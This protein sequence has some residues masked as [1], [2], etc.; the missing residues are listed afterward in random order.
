MTGYTPDEKLRLQQLRELRR[1]WLKDQELSP[2]EPVLPAQRMW[3]ME[4][5]WNKFLQDRAPWKNVIYKVYRTSIF[6][7]TCVLIPTWIV[8]YYVKYHVSKKPY[9][10]VERKPRIFPGDTILETG[11]VI[12]PMKEYPD[13]HH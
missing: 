2:R 1:R 8:H 12:P 3:P 6:A 10:I 7:V 13:Q 9:A 11:E 5:F 4:A